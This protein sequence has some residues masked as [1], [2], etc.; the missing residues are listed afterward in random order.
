MNWAIF[1]FYYL[2]IIWA[3]AKW[4]DT[5]GSTQTN[6]EESVFKELIHFITFIT[7]R[8]RNGKK[9][10]QQKSVHF[11]TLKIKRFLNWIV[12]PYCFAG[13]DESCIMLK[14]LFYEKI[15]KFKFVSYIKSLV[16]QFDFCEYQTIGTCSLRF[17]KN[18][19]IKRL[20]S[21]CW[22]KSY[23]WKITRWEL[24]SSLLSRRDSSYQ[25]LE[26]FTFEARGISKNQH[27]KVIKL[28]RVSHKTVIWGYFGG[29]NKKT[30][31]FGTVSNI[32]TKLL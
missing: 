19:W 3:S 23:L 30:K 18:R 22:W 31:N 5:R 28:F 7:F 29:P 25:I 14:M 8:Q 24:N 20:T 12:C 11:I 26:G 27:V 16:G 15:I 32:S 13:N 17:I 21:Y 9:T 1:I 4:I 2:P 6:Y 10:S